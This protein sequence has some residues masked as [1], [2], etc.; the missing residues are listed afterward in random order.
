MSW[1]VEDRVLAL[2]CF[3]LIQVCILLGFVIYHGATVGL[4]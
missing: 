3:L 2:A 4:T 1:H